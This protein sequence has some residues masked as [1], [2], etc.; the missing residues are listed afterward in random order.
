MK[1]LLMF[2]AFA[3]ALTVGAVTVMTVQPPQALAAPCDSANC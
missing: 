3:F 1:K 2:V